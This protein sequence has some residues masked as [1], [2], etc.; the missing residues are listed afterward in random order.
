MN[1][2]EQMIEKYIDSLRSLGMTEP[3]IKLSVI[4][5]SSGYDAATIVHTGELETQE[6]TDGYIV[7]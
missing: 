1:P 4:A 5:F 2:R 6:T 3:F 7:H